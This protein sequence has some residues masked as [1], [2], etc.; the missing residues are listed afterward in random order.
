[1][2]A[3]LRIRLRPP[4]QPTRYC[5]RTVEIRP[6]DVVTCPPGAKH[7]HGATDKTAMTHIAIQESKDGKNVE[8]LERVTD[9]QYLGR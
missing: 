4:S 6:G 3:A 1:M 5:A 2:P 7:W 9:E 8:W